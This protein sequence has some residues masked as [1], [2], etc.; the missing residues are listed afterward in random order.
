MNVLQMEGITKTFPGVKA[1]EGVDF[2]V[3]ESEVHG[4]L[5]ENGAGKSTLVK[6]LNGIYKKDGGKIKIKGKEV[7]IANPHDAGDLGIGMIHQ[8]LS[9]IPNLSVGENV[10]FGREMTKNGLIRF[11]EM[12]KG[13]SKLLKMLGSDIDPGTKVEKLTVGERQMV[14]IARTLSLNAK[15]IV[16]DEPT[17]ALSEAEVE[18]LFEILRSLKKEGISI[19]Y[20]THDLNEIVEIC[21]VATVLRN[22][23]FVGVADPHK[24]SK[25]EL[26]Q[27]ITG[28]AVKEVYPERKKEIGEVAL[29]VRGI[30]TKKTVLTRLSDVSFDVHKGEVLGVFGLMGAG[31]TEIA[32]ALF[33]IDPLEKGEIYFEGKKLK[34]RSAFEATNAGIA[35]VPEDRRLQGFVGPMSVADNV[36]FSSLDEISHLLF[37]QRS[38]ELRVV[39]GWI[40]QLK[41]VTPGTTQKTQNLSGG[42]QQ[43]VVVAKWLQTKPKILLIDEPTRGI[44]VGVKGDIRTIL[45]DLA[46]KG[47][48]IVLFSSE[49]DEILALSDSAVVMLNGKVAGKFTGGE[50]TMEKLMSYAMGAT[51]E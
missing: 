20:I 13:A 14:E 39:N 46:D 44:D 25:G 9:V 34:I 19:I 40:D 28:R 8:E 7:E 21:D 27:M 51:G 23:K 16:M 47:M 36:T 6:V 31:K 49:V 26:A 43:K 12:N 1:L 17:S 10:Y 22:G 18:K 4:L 2:S 15:I 3:E 35:L 24:I 48:A 45:S 38:K 32:R 5:G 50:I 42:N 30:S 33:G 11:S 37:I 29:S 41:I